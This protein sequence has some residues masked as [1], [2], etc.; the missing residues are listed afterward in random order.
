[1]VEFDLYGEGDFVEEYD[2]DELG[3]VGFGL[4]CLLVVD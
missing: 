1:M 4:E 3:C 2:C